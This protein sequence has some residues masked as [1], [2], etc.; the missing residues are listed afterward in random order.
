MSPILTGCFFGSALG[1]ILLMCL[2]AEPIPALIS[3]V[4]PSLLIIILAGI[5]RL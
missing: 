1:F 4:L 3:C 5:A 2:G